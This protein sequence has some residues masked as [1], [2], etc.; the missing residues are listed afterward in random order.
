MLWQSDYC[1]RTSTKLHSMEK[2]VKSRREGKAK[3]ETAAWSKQEVRQK[4]YFSNI[5][6]AAL[7]CSVSE[8]R[9]TS[10]LMTR[11]KENIVAVLKLCWRNHPTLQL[12]HA[13]S[14]SSFWALG[15]LTLQN[16]RAIHRIK[17]HY[18]VECGCVTPEA[19][20]LSV[21]SGITFLLAA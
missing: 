11:S 7:P 20:W 12:C 4:A 21:P 9:Q 19:L 2:S 13:C 1:E 3:K 6:P 16:K 10:S 15:R 5:R 17:L 8:S 14:H 18:M